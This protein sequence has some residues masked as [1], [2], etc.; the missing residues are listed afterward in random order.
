LAPHTADCII[1][2]W[3]PDRATCVAEALQGLVESFARPSGGADP[4]SLPLEAPPAG[5]ADQLVSLLEDVIY[6]LDVFSVVPV[7]VHLVDTEDGGIA[8]DMEVV[9]TSQVEEVGPV[10]KAV[11]YHELSMA[12]QRGGGWRCRVLVDV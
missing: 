10:P 9:P 4:R 7:G 5:P 1:E 2:A 11:S 6:A 12:R 3:G 8:G